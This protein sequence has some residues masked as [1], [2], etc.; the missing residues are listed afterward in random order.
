[1]NVYVTGISLPFFFLIYPSFSLRLSF[2]PFLSQFADVP[3]TSLRPK[4]PDEM[5]YF[6]CFYIT[7]LRLLLSFTSVDMK[8]FEDDEDELALGFLAK[9]PLF[10]LL[11][12]VS[13]AS[14]TLNV[15]AISDL[16]GS[17]DEVKER[18]MEHY[19]QAIRSQVY[20]VSDV[21]LLNTHTHTW[22][23][24]RALIHHQNL[25]LHTHSTTPTLT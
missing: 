20:V 11:M 4:P 5:I 3:L 24:D 19:W 18:V 1:M 2:S 21:R 9:Y 25:S 7:P 16:L 23:Y 13:D 14:I 12:N 22:I 15:L 17:Q 6:K 10:S 8:E